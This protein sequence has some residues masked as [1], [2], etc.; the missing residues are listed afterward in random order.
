MSSVLNWEFGKRDEHGRELI[1]VGSTAIPSGA[2]RLIVAV[3]CDSK[4]LYPILGFMDEDGGL[5]REDDPKTAEVETSIPLRWV[6]NVADGKPP[7]ET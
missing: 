7:Y 1:Q 5:I 4:Y 2:K 3:K 6:F